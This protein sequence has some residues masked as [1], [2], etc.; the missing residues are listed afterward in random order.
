MEGILPGDGGF[1]S[2]HSSQFVSGPV[3]LIN[4]QLAHEVGLSFC[5]PWA[6]PVDVTI[7]HV[8]GNS[9]LDFVAH[10]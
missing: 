9:E 3:V 4:V 5:Q 8:G 1:K 2:P 7:A 6:P 10:E